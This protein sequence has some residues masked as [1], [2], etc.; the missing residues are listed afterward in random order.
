MESFDELAITDE[1]IIGLDKAGYRGMTRIQ[2]LAIPPALEGNDIIACAKT[3]SGKTLAF[4]IPLIECL[5]KEEWTESDGLGA[6]VITP[7]RELAVQIFEVIRAIG[8]EHENLSVGLI[9]GGM[10]VEQER[11]SISL[12]SILIGTPGRILHHFDESAGLDVGN[13]KMLV[14]DEADRLLD[15]G[16]SKNVLAILEHLPKAGRQTLLFS[17]TLP[18]ETQLPP[19]LDMKNPTI[20]SALT[21]ATSSTPLRLCQ[22]FVVCD[23]KDKLSLLYS[24]IL[25]HDRQKTIIFASTC[26]QVKYYFLALSRILKSKSVPCACLTGKMKQHQRQ[27]VFQVFC[28]RPSMV[29]FSTDVACRGLD[30]PQV[31]WVVQLDCPDSAETYIHRVGRTARAGGKGSSLLVL[32]PQETAILPYL[33]HAKIPLREVVVRDSRWKEVTEAMVAEVAQGLKPEAVKAFVSYIRGV[34]FAE[35]KYV[36]NVDNIDMDAFAKSLGLMGVPNTDLLKLGIRTKKNRTWEDVNVDLQQHAQQATTTT[37]KET[38]QNLSKAAR[39]RAATH[40]QTTINVA[41]S[42]VAKD[43]EDDDDVLVTVGTVGQGD[44]RMS[45]EDVTGVDALSKKSQ[46]LLKRKDGIVDMRMAKL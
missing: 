10:D 15:A 26:H 19:Q 5:A 2:R 7:T 9:T 43:D 11:R 4:L 8:A 27:E 41:K 1:T 39:H 31:K 37:P 45:K 32:T 44:V 35:N 25:S 14:L 6:L 38:Q 20:V 23:L 21:Q 22:N 46:M 3:G 28:E 16:F 34:H 24:F 33:H 17:A 13:L 42:F 30:F 12:M 18:L 40:L 29:L 36:F